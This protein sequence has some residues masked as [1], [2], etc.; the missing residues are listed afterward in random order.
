MCPVRNFRRFVERNA[1]HTGE[2]HQEA[3]LER[4]IAKSRAVGDYAMR[5]IL[6]V[7]AYWVKRK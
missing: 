2:G 3:G 6:G 5:G 4:S 1:V 7:M